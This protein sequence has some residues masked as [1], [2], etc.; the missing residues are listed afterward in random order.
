VPTH[1][2]L[3]PDCPP[4]AGFGF[5][6][7]SGRTGPGLR[8]VQRLEA[9]GGGGEPN[10]VEAFT[11]A[12]SL[13]SASKRKPLVHQTPDGANRRQPEPLS[14]GPRA[15]ANEGAEP[16]LR[17]SPRKRPHQASE[18]GVGRVDS[19]GLAGFVPGVGARRALV[20]GEWRACR[21]VK[22]ELRRDETAMSTNL[23]P[24]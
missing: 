7:R 22:Q 1:P 12:R 5:G 9:L 10:G 3:A 15:D 24:V 23:S 17:E 18:P 11:S 14:Q 20:S 13:P 6:S 8:S 16:R 21:N 4:L 2:A 19:G